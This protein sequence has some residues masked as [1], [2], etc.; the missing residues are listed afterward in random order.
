MNAST[1]STLFYFQFT[2]LLLSTATITLLCVLYPGALE[3]LC[4]NKLN[5]SLDIEV[6]RIYLGIHINVRSVSWKY[7]S[8]F[9]T[10]LTN[11]KIN[12]DGPFLHQG[13]L[14]HFSWET[15]EKSRKRWLAK[16]LVDVSFHWNGFA[17]ESWIGQLLLQVRDNEVKDIR[18]ETPDVKTSYFRSWNAKFSETPYINLS[19]RYAWIVRNTHLGSNANDIPERSQTEL[20]GNHEQHFIKNFTW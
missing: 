18:D 14:R 16:R 17:K 9:S 15:L 6:A 5:A 20:P 2:A 3:D 8:A 12:L 1:S 11:R 4:V 10:C 7:S 19:Q 13:A